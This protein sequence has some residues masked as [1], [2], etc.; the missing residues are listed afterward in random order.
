MNN[1]QMQITL[2]T[3]GACSG[4]PGPG[5]FAAI[6]VAQ[7]QNGKVLREKEIVGSEAFTTNNRMELM[8]VIAGLKALNQPAIV[9]IVS[10]SQYVIHTITKNWKRK[11][12]NDLWQELDALISQHTVEWKY[13]K[14][15][16]GHEYNERCDKL[17][18]AQIESLR[19]TNTSTDIAIAGV[20]VYIGIK[21]VNNSKI[22]GWATIIE[23]NSKKTEL[24][25]YLTNTSLKQL[26]M[27]AL[28][29]ALEIINSP[30]RVFIYTDSEYL[31]KGTSVWLKGW[32]RNNWITS[33][34]SPVRYKEQW[35]RLDALIQ[36][37]DLNWQEVERNVTQEKQSRIQYL[38]S[39][40]YNNYKNLD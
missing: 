25:G 22:G 18:V 40:A 39:E 21:Y 19:N 29:A 17:A 27:V 20:H 15:H 33:E 2:Y 23:S 13:V 37:H 38:A 30:S 3:D 7:D 36:A 16:S 4:N 24:S 31:K 35:K 8:A 12:N 5:G 10:D 1:P 11:K 34:G 26:E 6:L 32:K 28:L 9:K 14:G